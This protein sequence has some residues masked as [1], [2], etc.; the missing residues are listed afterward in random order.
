MNVLGLKWKWC[1]L[2]QQPL[3][4]L[5]KSAGRASAHATSVPFSCGSGNAVDFDSIVAKAL[6]ELPLELVALAKDPK[7]HAKSKDPGWKYGFWP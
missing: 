3:L 2:V 1:F 5:R 4:K 7:R 6:D